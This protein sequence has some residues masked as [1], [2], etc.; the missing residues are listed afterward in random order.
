MEDRV[1]RA[2][3]RFRDMLESAQA[4][5]GQAAGEH[6]VGVQLS[7][8]MLSAMKFMNRAGGFLEAVGIVNPELGAELL[9]EFEAFAAKIEVPLEAWQR[10][11]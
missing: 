6:P 4:A 11:A 8:S 7:S 1:Q 2:R 10:A 9:A 3:Q 5:A